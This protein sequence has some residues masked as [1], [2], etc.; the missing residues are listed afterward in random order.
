MQTM[1]SI[2]ELL[3]TGQESQVS[4]MTA[5]SAPTGVQTQQPLDDR[6]EFL[7]EMERMKNLCEI[8]E[9][10]LDEAEHREVLWEE[11]MQKV[12][13]ETLDLQ[14][15]AEMSQNQAREFQAQA[16]HWANDAARSKKARAI[17]EDRN[18]RQ[19]EILEETCKIEEL[20]S[21]ANKNLALKLARLEKCME[22]IDDDQVRRTMG[23]LY[24]ELKDWIKRHFPCLL[25]SN[26]EELESGFHIQTLHGIQAEVYGLISSSILRRLF[27]GILDE[28]RECLFREL[29]QQ[30]FTQCKNLL[31]TQVISKLIEPPGPN[32]I[33]HQWRSATSN[34]LFSLASP[35]LRYY[36]DELVS[37]IEARFGNHSGTDE[38][39]RTREMQLLL[40]KF[41]EFK[42]RLNRQK[43]R[44]TFWWLVPGM[45]F[46]QEH[47]ASVTGEQPS[48][49]IVQLCL[50][51]IL[52][53]SSPRRDGHAIVQKATVKLTMP[54]QG[55]DRVAAKVEL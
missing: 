6:I 2:R 12:A 39:T 30:V 18:R 50:S 48:S 16:E 10:K 5:L 11:Q 9:R 36:C 7:T 54:A 51:P 23:D 38:V 49:A 41:V 24:Q 15:K 25:P 21:K 20:V 46:N 27:V 4:A 42:N 32:H 8:F 17:V 26:E 35:D 44:Y 52:S 31:Y 1:E 28:S 3:G 37:I 55:Q 13:T 14:M 19:E 29:D 43:E 22:C 45:P 47:M 53:K 40:W 34:A 33:W